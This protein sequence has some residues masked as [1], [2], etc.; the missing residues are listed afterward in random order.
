MKKCVLVAMVLAFAAESF[1]QDGRVLV[2]YFSKGGNTEKVAQEIAAETGGTL[3]RIFAREPYPVEK[4]AN[5]ERAKD[6]YRRGV[7]PEIECEAADVSGYDVVFIGYPLWCGHAPVP[8][9]TFLE[10]HDFSGKT[11]VPFVTYGGAR[12]PV[13]QTK[14]AK[15]RRTP[16]SE[17]QSPFGHRAYRSALE[18]CGARHGTRW[19]MRGGRNPRFESRGLP[20]AKTFSASKRFFQ[21][22]LISVF[23]PQYL[24]F[25]FADFLYT[26]KRSGWMQRFT[27]RAF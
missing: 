8:V 14:S 1:A 3:A 27:G 16:R 19:R 20:F 11:I 4:Q 22:K 5:M 13:E 18:K 10:A 25:L 23:F 12:S 17:R 7:R 15:A 6:E 9:L 24:L 26:E 21:H 2:A